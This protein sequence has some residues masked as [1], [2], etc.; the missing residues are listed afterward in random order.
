MDGSA[1]RLP[2]VDGW[3]IT[4]Q[5]PDIAAMGQAYLDYFEVSEQPHAVQAAG[6]KPE[7]DLAAYRYRLDR[8][9]RRAARG[10]LEQLVATVD[11]ALPLAVKGVAE[12]SLDH[13][14]N[15]HTEQVETAVGE[16]ARLLGDAAD[17]IG[18]WWDL[19][20]HL[21]FSQ[22]TTGATSSSSTGPP[23][24]PTSSPMPWATAIRCPFRTWT[25]GRQPPATSR[26]LPPWHCPG[27]GWTT[28]ASSVSSTTSCAA[29][30]STRTSSG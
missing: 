3:T 14:V 22:G 1:S 19:H 21:R 28:T 24:A 11:T 2:P 30:R 27:S 25:W 23:C 29:S 9:R 20:R 16:I 5:L 7:A 10:R 4:E 8:A 26:G 17:T 18:R 13:L 6:E 12:D 15:A